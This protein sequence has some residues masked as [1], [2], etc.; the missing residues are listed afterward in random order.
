ME[1]GAKSMEAEEKIQELLGWLEKRNIDFEFLRH[2]EGTTTKK[3]SQALGVEECAVLKSLLFRDKFKYFIGVVI[4]GDR[5]VSL[6]SLNR[7]TGKIFELA[8]PKEVLEKTGYEVGGMPPFAFSILDITGYIDSSV[9]RSR[10][11][12]GSAGTPTSG[13]KFSPFALGKVGYKL[14]DISEKANDNE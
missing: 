4:A 11:V 2:A 7:I 3:A 14:V 8:T 12:Y 5:K 10:D 6:R 13:I 9:L 1:K